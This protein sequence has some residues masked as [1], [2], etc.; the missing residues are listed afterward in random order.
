MLTL[1]RADNRT[2]P[3]EEASAHPRWSRPS[4][5]SKPLPQLAQTIDS[6][7]PVAHP[8]GVKP[9]TRY[10]SKRAIVQL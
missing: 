5:V 1:Q 4:K 8:F 10:P 7:K 3:R 6:A 2:V 9:R